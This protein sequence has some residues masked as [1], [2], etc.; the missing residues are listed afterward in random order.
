MPFDAPAGLPVQDKFGGSWPNAY[1]KISR[2]SPHVDTNTLTVTVS[3]W[4]RKAFARKAT[5]MGFDPIAQRDYT[6]SG[7]VYTSFGIETNSTRIGDLLTAIEAAI[8]A[9]DPF[10]LNWTPAT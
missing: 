7:A 9:S 1:A 2:W 6:F 4:G 3:I 10:F 5:E 8:K